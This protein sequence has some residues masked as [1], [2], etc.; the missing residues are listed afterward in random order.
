MYML[1]WNNQKNYKWKANSQS[2]LQSYQDLVQR[3]EPVIMELERQENVLVICHQA[4]MRCLLAYFLDK[5]AGRYYSYH[6]APVVLVFIISKVIPMPPH[7]F[8]FFLWITSSRWDALS[9]VSPPHCAKAHTGCL[10]L[11]SGV[12]LSECGGGEHPQ[13][14]T[15]G[16]AWY[17]CYISYESWS[18]YHIQKGCTDFMCLYFVTYRR[19]REALAA[20]S[21]GTVWLRWPALSQTSR[22]PASM[23]WTRLPSKSCLPRSPQWLSAVLPTFLWLWQDR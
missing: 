13:R 8:K 12:H 11:Q 1:T 9:E 14:Q 4:V 15:R 6:K 7:L 16:N 23:T 19:W 21:G 17:R 10:W 3:V 20:W 18:C 5:S 22:N 2:L